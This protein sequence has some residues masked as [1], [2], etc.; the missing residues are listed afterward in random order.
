MACA[1]GPDVFPIPGTRRSDRL[2]ENVAAFAL[3]EKLTK[4]DLEELEACCPVGAAVGD[5][6]VESP[7]TYLMVNRQ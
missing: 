5:R 6:S 1:Q 3:S 4:R 2:E 7:C